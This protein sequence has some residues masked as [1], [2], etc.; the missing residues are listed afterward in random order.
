MLKS[1]SYVCFDDPETFTKEDLAKAVAE[2]KGDLF[3]QDDV[4]T[5]LAKEKRKTQETQ[6]QLAE[7]LTQARKAANLTAEEKA[8]ADAQIEELEKKYMTADELTRQ[9]TDKQTKKHSQ[10]LEELKTSKSEWQTRFTQSTIEAS[11]TKAAADNEAIQTDQVAAMLRPAA[12]LAETADENGKPT[13][14]YEVRVDFQD[15]DKDDKPIVLNLTVAEAVKR[16]AELERFGNLFKGG[17]IGGTGGTGGD[18]S[19]PVDLNSMSMA[20]YRELRKDPVKF[21]AALAG[22]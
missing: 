22:K 11:I 15:L 12:K 1:V 2:A 21:A 14:K 5:I 6:K 4:N 19:K 16:M 10:E 9:A 3:N 17:K 7:Q 18:T 20:N 8:V 13:G